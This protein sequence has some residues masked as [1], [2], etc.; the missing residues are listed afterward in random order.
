[1]A[2]PNFNTQ[3]LSL[4]VAVILGCAAGFNMTH[5]FTLIRFL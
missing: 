2:T 3:A 4:A 1:L 5:W